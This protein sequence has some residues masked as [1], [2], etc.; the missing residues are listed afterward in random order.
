[1]NPQ[2][3]TPMRSSTLP[4]L[5]L[6]CAVLLA[7]CPRNIPPPDGAL[8]HAEELRVAIDARVSTIED[9]RF[10]EVVL[11]YF[12]DG[13]RV[14]VR[15]LILVQQPDRLRV[16]T[17]IPGS[18]EILN[19]LVSD[20]ETF[21]MH[22]RDTNEYYTGAPTREN[23][24]LLLPVDLSGRDVVRVML[25]GAPWDRFAE[26]G[27]VPEMVWDRRRGLY[28]YSVTRSDGNVLS[29]W[30]RH[31]DY[32]VIEMQEVTATDEL[33]YSYQTRGWRDAGQVSL[34][35][36][37]RFVWPARDLDFSLDVGDTQLNI[38]LD[39]HLFEL[40]PPPGSR[41]YELAENRNRSSHD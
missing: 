8:Q 9:A 22:Q 15:Q 35:A 2:P 40:P 6:L 27:G 4:G 19:L 32:A 11:E 38:S 37:R 34:P 12:G 3:R 28:E 18:D 36:H 21:S 7:G 31:D 29:M 5:L 14:R 10:R 23:I 33:V 1:L 41:I 24:N 25:G 17:R 13:E 39:G 26:G 16:Q 20:G 30:V